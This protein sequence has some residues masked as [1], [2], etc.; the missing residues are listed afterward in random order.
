MAF[1]V[2]TFSVSAIA[3]PIKLFKQNLPATAKKVTAKSHHQ[4]FT[5]FS[6]TWKSDFCGGEK[7]L[8]ITINNN[9]DTF[10]ISSEDDDSITYITDGSLN[11]IAQFKDDESTTIDTG[12]AEW[13]TDTANM[14]T[15]EVVVSKFNFRNDLFTIFMNA[16][17]SLNESKQLHIQGQAALYVDSYSMSSPMAENSFDCVFKKTP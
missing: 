5:D 11:Q 12:I 2:S 10:T 17:Y 6:G 16:N 3:F 13:S 14:R 1:V 9:S 7:D 15:R 4:N 8:V